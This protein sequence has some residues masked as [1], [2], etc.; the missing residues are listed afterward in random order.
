MRESQ[1]RRCNYFVLITEPPTDAWDYICFNLALLEWLIPLASHFGWLFAP[2]GLAQAPPSS[3]PTPHPLLRA[4][5]CPGVFCDCSPCGHHQHWM[6]RGPLCNVWAVSYRAVC[7]SFSA[8]NLSAGPGF[9]T[10][11][12]LGRT[13]PVVGVSCALGLFSST[14]A[15]T[16]R[17]Q[18][19]LPYLERDNAISQNISGHCQWSELGM[20]GRG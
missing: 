19:H 7:P 13:I 18:C 2:L 15:S 20:G 5:S 9:S 11:D 4:A 6:L 1:A 10:V 12:I 8:R 14:L 17:F 3:F 16:Y